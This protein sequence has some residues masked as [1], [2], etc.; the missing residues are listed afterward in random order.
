MIRISTISTWLLGIT[1]LPLSICAILNGHLNVIELLISEYGADVL[2]P[3]KLDPLGSGY[4]KA[5]IPKGAIM[6]ITL[7]A[8]C[9][10]TDSAIEVAR[11]LLKLGATSAQSD[12]D[13][14]T[15]LH[16]LAAMDAGDILDS[17]FEYDRPAALSV[18]NSVG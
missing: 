9:Q 7:A 14:F 8:M 12:M 18:L 2:L 3:V 1:A 11:L 17:L 16:T 5:I 6:T 10:P 15:V 4:S 13:R